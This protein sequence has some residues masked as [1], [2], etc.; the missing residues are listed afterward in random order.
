M[1][2]K[3]LNREDKKVL[4]TNIHKFFISKLPE[5]EDSLISLGGS[6]V[7]SFRKAYRTFKYLKKIFCFTN[8]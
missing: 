5:H 3:F 8:S 7:V 4:L 2:F 6:R 1:K